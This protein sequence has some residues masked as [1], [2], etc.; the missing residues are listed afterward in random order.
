MDGMG[1]EPQKLS[2]FASL[3]VKLFK[4]E[5]EK[6]NHTGMRFWTIFSL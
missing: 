6:H 5:K 4:P 2:W 3:D 1:L